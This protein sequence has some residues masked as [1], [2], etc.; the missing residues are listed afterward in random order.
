MRCLNILLIDLN[1]FSP[2]RTIQQLLTIFE[3]EKVTI[4]Q[5]GRSELHTLSAS[6]ATMHD[7]FS[8]SSP[9][10]IFLVANK[11][12]STNIVTVIAKLNNE[13]Q[14]IPLIAVLEDAEP[15]D[16][17]ELFKVGFT[18]FITPP[19]RAVDV[20]PRLWRLSEHVKKEESLTERLKKTIGLKQLVGR[21]PLFCAELEKI[22]FIARCDSSVLISGETGTG[23]DMFARAIHYLGARSCK[24]FT[25]LN[26]GSI[27]SDLIENEL[28][29]HARGA[30]TSAVTS[31]EG[32][33]AETDGGTLFLD[34]ID[35]LSSNAQVKLL[36]FLQEKE[37]RQ[38]GSAKTR[39]A[40]V[41]VI[42]ATNIDLEQAV[43]NHS[44]RRD[45][46]YRLNII[47]LGLPPLR[48]RREDIPVLAK[49]FVDQYAL[50]FKK[51]TDEIAPEAMHKL[52]SYDWPGNVRELQNVI[53]RAVVFSDKNVLESQNFDIPQASKDI[54]AETFQKAKARVVV[55]FE[56]EYIH[57]LLTAHRGNI[58]H[59]AR[60]AGKNR[61]AFWELIRKHQIDVESFR[62]PS[63]RS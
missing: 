11:T 41:R 25:P 40:D 32:I 10:I 36:R 4:K 12:I 28:F 15:P 55:E 1:P 20:I 3:T 5:L 63:S 31:V 8:K 29:G 43:Q 39:R 9:D 27:P 62:S 58:T 30:F 14:R 60:I 34:E 17:I 38:L 13:P 24:P 46:Y 59:A 42:A 26:C 44:F 7:A 50:E 22:P 54:F 19:F 37:Y 57:S 53:E 33:V 51:E 49:H 6:S 21:S 2:S 35:C 18:D 45:L 47:P 61:R 48:N 16:M 52:L 23:K 56:K